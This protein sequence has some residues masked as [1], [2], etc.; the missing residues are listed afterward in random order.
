MRSKP[1]AISEMDR[2]PARHSISALNSGVNDRRSRRV[3]R[4]MVSMMG[5]VS[6]AARLLVD[7]R[8]AVPTPVRGCLG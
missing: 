2:S 3:S 4:S 1:R 6:G 7:V 8:H 5:I